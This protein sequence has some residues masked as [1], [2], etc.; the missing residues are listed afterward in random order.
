MYG[1]KKFTSSD[2]ARLD[3]FLK[4]EKPNKNV[5]VLKGNIRKT[6]DRC[7]PTCFRVL[8]KKILRITSVS[9]IWHNTF[10]SNITPSFPENF[11]WNLVE[12]NYKI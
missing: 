4:K 5:N 6:D 9:K 3:I 2:E 10:N 8:Q 12:E 1:K 7:L 11:G